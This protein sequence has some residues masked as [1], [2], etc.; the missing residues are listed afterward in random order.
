MLDILFVGS[1][2]YSETSSRSGKIDWA[3]DAAIG[4]HTLAAGS[5]AK[6]D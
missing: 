1:A 4:T 2:S 6:T 3:D 5:A